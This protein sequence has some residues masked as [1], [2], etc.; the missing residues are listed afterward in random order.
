[1]RSSLSL[2]LVVALLAL[3]CASSVVDARKPHGRHHS[4]ASRRAPASGKKPFVPTPSAAAAA[5]PVDWYKTHWCGAE[6]EYLSDSKCI[7]AFPSV[8]NRSWVSPV[9]VSRV[10]TAADGWAQ[11]TGSFAD[12]KVD[13]TALAEYTSDGANVCVILIKRPVSGGVYFKYLCGRGDEDTH[14]AVQPWSSTKIY[15]AANAGGHIREVCPQSGLVSATEGEHG[16]TPLGDLVSIITSYDSTQSYTSNGLSFYMHDLG[17]RYRLLGLVQKWFGPLAVN[18]SL[19][20]NYGMPAP[21]DLGFDLHQ[22]QA[23]TCHVVNDTQHINLNALSVLAHVDILRRLTLSFD[24][25]ISSRFP[26]MQVADQRTIMYGAEESLLFPGLQ[27]GGMTTSLDVYVQSG[28]PMDEVEQRS[29]GQ[30]RIFSKMGA[31]WDPE[32]QVGDVLTATYATLPVL[33]A[34]GLPLVDQGVEFLVVGRSSVPQDSTLVKT[35]AIL[36]KA[37]ASIAKAIYEGQIA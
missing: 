23:P 3:L 30:W 2:L 26:N 27:W 6:P 19:G 33:D 18:L 29:R 31:G 32:A 22:P 7:K 11:D 21:P 16:A 24:L 14:Q 12:V 4:H 8:H 35:D 5:D 17:G 36:Q 28:L 25:P 1:M 9:R 37:V 13:S 15:A 10:P 34:D 20:G